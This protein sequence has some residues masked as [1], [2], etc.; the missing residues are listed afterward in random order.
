MGTACSSGSLAKSGAGEISGG[1]SDLPAGRGD[2]NGIH[3][4]VDQ[5]LLELTSVHVNFWN[6]LG[7]VMG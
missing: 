6:S 5:G 1:E 4:K 3:G 7:Q 2:L